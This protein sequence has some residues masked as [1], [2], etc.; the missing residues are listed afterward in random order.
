MPRMKNTIPSPF[1][2]VSL[3]VARLRWC[4]G[5]RGGAAITDTWIIPPT[6]KAVLN[7]GGNANRPELSRT[8]TS[9]ADPYT[10]HAVV[11]RHKDIPFMCTDLMSINLI[12]YWYVL[13]TWIFQMFCFFSPLLPLCQRFFRPV[14]GI[15]FEMSSFSG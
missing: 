2:V 8:V 4:H 9:R 5:S 12:S 15:K 14:A 6:S 3:F 11:Q 7:C 1:F 13:S 10:Y